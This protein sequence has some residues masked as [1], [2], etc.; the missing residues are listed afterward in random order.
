MCR[1]ERATAATGSC[2]ATAPTLAAKRAI[3]FDS[4]PTRSSSSAERETA[5]ADRRSLATGWCSAMKVRLS[6]SIRDS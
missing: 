3:F 1:N 4:S 2:G 5:R 6:R